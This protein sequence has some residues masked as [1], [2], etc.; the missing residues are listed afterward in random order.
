MA[1]VSFGRRRPPPSPSSGAARSPAAPD[2]LDVAAFDAS[3]LTVYLKDAVALVL[4]NRP[5]DPV[6][7]I[8][9]YLRRV[10]HGASP[11]AR[12]HQYLTL[13]PHHR[14]AFVD[15]AVVAH[16]VLGAASGP[17]GVVTGAQH[18]ALLERLCE[19]FPPETRRVTVDA[20]ARA[21]DDAV[22]FFEFLGGAKACRA[23]AELLEELDEEERRGGREGGGREG[24]GEG[25]GGGEDKD[26][27]AAARDALAAEVARAAAAELRGRGGGGGGGGERGGRSRSEG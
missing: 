15:N 16:D 6:A 19:D 9:E 10:L 11:V 21:P 7:F 14:D 2:P 8:A 27:A 23:M 3:S 25:G 5:D 17:R 13:S 18:A 12:A 22:D 20:F 26:A 1:D 4:E 24:E